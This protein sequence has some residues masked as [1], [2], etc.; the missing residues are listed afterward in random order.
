MNQ[1][2]LS[3]ACRCFIW[4]TWESTASAAILPFGVLD[5]EQ[6]SVVYFPETG[7]VAVD[8][9]AGVELTSINMG[10]TDVPGTG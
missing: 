7:E 9:P 4:A 3:I 6:T 1:P 2:L 5:D 8:A 10:V